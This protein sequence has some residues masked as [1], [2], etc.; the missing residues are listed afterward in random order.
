MSTPAAPAARNPAPHRRRERAGLRHHARVALPRTA[1]IEAAAAQP[2]Q[3]AGSAAGAWIARHH[4][5]HYGQ[6]S[7]EHAWR[8]CGYASRTITLRP[9][10][11]RAP[12]KCVIRGGALRAAFSRIAMQHSGMDKNAHPDEKRPG[13]KCLGLFYE[14]GRSAR[15]HRPERRAGSRRRWSS[16][17][18]YGTFDVR[19]H[20]ITGEVGCRGNAR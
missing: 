6:V 16:A 3:K 5:Q 8:R 12:G 1:S 13:S 19:G 11:C 9:A 10:R 7:F 14:S 20:L 17:V 18:H 2:R 15:Q 4:P